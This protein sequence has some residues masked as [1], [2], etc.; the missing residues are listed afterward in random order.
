MDLIDGERFGECFDILDLERG[1]CLPVTLAG[2][3][4]KEFDSGVGDT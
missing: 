1:E 3:R 2:T 4:V